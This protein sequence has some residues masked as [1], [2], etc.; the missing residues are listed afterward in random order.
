M[1]LDEKAVLNLLHISRPTLRKLRE[2]GHIR[3]VPAGR[4]VLYPRRAI[5]EYLGELQ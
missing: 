4:R 5:L 2:A 1:V 3:F